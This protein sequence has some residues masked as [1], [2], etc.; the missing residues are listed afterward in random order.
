MLG[1]PRP[2][3]SSTTRRP[4]SSLPATSR[5]SATAPHGPVRRHRRPFHGPSSGSPAAS[6]GLEDAQ[7]AARQVDRPCDK[8]V[9]HAS[10]A[11]IRL[12]EGVSPDA[13]GHRAQPC[14]TA[15]TTSATRRAGTRPPATAARRRRPRPIGPEPG[16]VRRERLSPTRAAASGRAHVPA[17]AS[18]SR[19]RTPGATRRAR[20]GHGRPLGHPPSRGRR[21][22]PSASSVTPRITHGRASRGCRTRSRTP[23]GPARR[24][25]RS[26]AA[27]RENASSAP[28][29]RSRSTNRP[30]SRSCG[31]TNAGRN[32]TG[33]NSDRANAL[34]NSPSDMPSTALPIASA[35]SPVGDPPTSRVRRGTPLPLVIPAWTAATTANANPY[36]VRR[37]ELA[38][39]GIDDQPLERPAVRSR[40]TVIEVTR[41]HRHERKEPD[42]Q[43]RR[44]CRTRSGCAIEDKPEQRHQERRARRAARSFAVAAKLA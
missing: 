27:P 22:R 40:S 10:G 33:S 4:R 29:I 17:R 3:P 19:S 38:P 43:G 26:G 12:A 42:Q 11:A 44:G 14:S 7:P 23:P 31:S 32:W 5:A 13:R 9:V 36:P 20:R 35:I 16:L 8:I 15:P 24:R 25:R 30:Q 37:V 39:T 18:R 2:Q 41:R 34:T 6:R 28:A 1:R 21:L